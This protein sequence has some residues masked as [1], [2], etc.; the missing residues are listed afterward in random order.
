MYLGALYP[1]MI[2]EDHITLPTIEWLPMICRPVTNMGVKAYLNYF[3]SIL[4]KF[5]LSAK[6]PRL[7]PE[8]QNLLQLSEATRVRDWYIFED[9]PLIWV[10]GMEEHEPFKLLAFLT[11][12][13]FAVEYIW[14]RFLS[15]HVH[16]SSRRASVTFKLPQE[17]DPFFIK[18]R[19]AGYKAEKLLRSMHLETSGK[20]VYDPHNV[21]YN[22]RNDSAKE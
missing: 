15:D 20:W 19:L 3:M 18:N 1:R 8:T 21:I 10:Y 7:L 5:L 13:M 12:R 14:Q 16:F 2:N 6:L 22:L 4:E 17:V 9:F 11:L